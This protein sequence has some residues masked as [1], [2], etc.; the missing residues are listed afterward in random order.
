MWN[1]INKFL[2]SSGPQDVV[3]Y[4]AKCWILNNIS[5]PILEIAYFL[6]LTN[7]KP[8]SKMEISDFL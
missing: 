2:A 7:T 3:M 4:N 6:R 8:T 1:A 5:E